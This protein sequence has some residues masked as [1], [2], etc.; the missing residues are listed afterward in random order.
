MPSTSIIRPKSLSPGTTDTIDSNRTDTNSDFL[1]TE[2][3]ANK[4][5]RSSTNLLV[6]FR[7]Q[8]TSKKSPASTPIINGNMRQHLTNGTTLN[9]SIE[10]LNKS[11]IK[12]STSKLNSFFH[13]FTKES[14]QVHNSNVKHTK[15]TI[16]LSDNSTSANS[17]PPTQPQSVLK[18]PT[19]NSEA[20]A[21]SQRS[22]HAIRRKS[23]VEADSE[24]NDQHINDYEHDEIRAINEHVHEY[25]YAVRILPGQNPRSVF[26]GWI[27]SR[28]RPILQKDILQDDTSMTPANKLSKLIRH[29]TVTQTAEDG[30]IIESVNRQDAYMFCASDLLENMSDH[31]TVARHVVNGLLIGCL[32]DVSTGQLTFYVNGTES[33]QKLEVCRIYFLLFFFCINDF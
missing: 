12:T 20:T 4:P 1:S 15:R 22:S 5:A 17:N 32:C 2:S 29:C 6:K 31:E 9:Q 24:F 11:T 14:Q 10:P 16:K 27:T 19:M 13:C 8:A 7:D 30:S 21:A 33:A 3:I 18:V 26:I 28:F 23:F 25:Y